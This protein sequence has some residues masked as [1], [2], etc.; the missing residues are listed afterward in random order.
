MSLRERKKLAVEA[1]L[2]VML[3]PTLGDIPKHLET[4][5]DW[6]EKRWSQELRECFPG[7]KRTTISFPK[8][9][10]LIRW[11]V[12][13]PNIKGHFWTNS[14]QTVWYF[15]DEESLLYFKMMKG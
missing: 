9:H 2:K 13:D 8:E 10:G 7:I 12:D 3:D 14:T 15:T 4:P 11:C 6:R 1:Y 5:P